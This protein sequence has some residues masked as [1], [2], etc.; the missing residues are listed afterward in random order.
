LSYLLDT[1]VLSEIRKG[2]RCHP[3]VARWFAA[4]GEDEIFLSV[5]VIG[6]IR[7]GI[8][9]A[10]PRDP[11]KAQAIE[12]WLEVVRSAF[13]GRILGVDLAVAE[14]W[15]RM[16][17]RRTFPA[18]DGL[19]AATARVHDLTLAT[20]DVQDLAGSGARLLDPFSGALSS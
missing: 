6:E 18:I 11:G 3:Q 17:A 7:Q 16:N 19:L 12:G 5:L 4:L 8:E 14:E 20:R 1:N 15:G 2:D 13:A 9:R 10:R